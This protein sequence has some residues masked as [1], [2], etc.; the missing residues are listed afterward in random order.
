MRS[1]AMMCLWAGGNSELRRAS[2]AAI[3]VSLE[4]RLQMVNDVDKVELYNLLYPFLYDSDH[5]VVYNAG[6]C[7]QRLLSQDL[8]DESSI[9]PS[10]YSLRLTAIIASVPT[11]AG[12]IWLKLMRREAARK[13]ESSFC[14]IYDSSSRKL[15]ADEML[16][17]IR[18]LLGIPM[19]ADASSAP[20]PRGVQRR[21]GTEMERLPKQHGRRG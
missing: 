17:T 13:S 6:L 10:L 12:D 5:K 21:G 18:V 11:P 2:T 1:V 19:D 15:I 8:S 14:Q 9:W 20:P 3:A 16:R 4:S 7:L